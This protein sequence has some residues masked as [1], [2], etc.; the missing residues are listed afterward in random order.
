MPGTRTIDTAFRADRIGTCAFAVA[1]A[2]WIA[3]LATHLPFVNAPPAVA[4]PI[5]LGTQLVAAAWI[6]RRWLGG[7][8]TLTVVVTSAAAGIVSSLINLLILGAFL[9]EAPSDA[10]GAPTPGVAGLKPGALVTAMGFVA[11]G[12]LIGLLGGVMGSVMRRSD[13]T[14]QNV[15]PGVSWVARLAL[16]ACVAI[17]PLLIL[18]GAVTSTAS[19]MAVRGWPDSYGANMFLFP[20]SLMSN[21]RI[22]F[23]HAHR[24]FG[25]L[26]G[27]TTLVLMLLALWRGPSRGVRLGAVSVF[28]LVCVQGVLGGARVLENSRGFALLHGVLAQ[29]TFAAAVALAVHSAPGFRRAAPWEPDLKHRLTRVTATGLLH[30][31]VLQLVLGAAYRHFGA[32]HALYTHAAFSFVV[33]TMAAVLGF[34]LLGWAPSGAGC[35]WW[36]SRGMGIE[37]LTM[38][39][40]G[41]G[42]L[43]SVL[44]QFLLGWIAFYAVLTGPAKGPVPL[45][46]QIHTAA[47]IDVWRSSVATLHH[48]N[49]A[50]VLALATATYV[51]AR[52]IFQKPRG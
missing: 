37:R 34:A 41:L 8:A 19:G 26:V 15:D 51:W 20:I 9:V 27:L 4:G 25:S 1:V 24:L 21:P 42:L 11:A 35:G 31:L 33:V 13:A 40:L 48:T 28:V 10:T 49:G 18:G 38:R 44:V 17:A 52:R 22:F 29:L 46:E 3:W 23:E 39:R 30:A 14:T 50:F 47:P 36:G 45:P 6:A 5:V 32:V 7:C 2:M 16:V 43:A 12:A